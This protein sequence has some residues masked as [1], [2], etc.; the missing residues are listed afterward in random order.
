VKGVIVAAG[1]GTRFLPVTKT[2]PKEMLPILDRP[3]LDHVVRELIEADVDDLLVISSRRKRALED[4]FDRDLELEQVFEREGATA[5]RAKI[6][7]PPIRVT[8]IRQTEMR[9]AGQALLL[10][11]EF[12]GKDPVIV[13]YPDDL[14]GRPN[15]SAQLVAA[16]RETGK[17]VLA[18]HDLPGAD[19][20]RYGVL[21]VAGVGPV[22]DVR[23][24]VEK[25]LPG[26]APSSVVSLGRYL[27][28]PDLFPLLA[29]GWARHKEGEFF[30]QDAINELAA[31]GRVAARIVDAAR[32]DT[33]TPLGLLTAAI[34][35]ALERPDLEGPLRSWLLERLRD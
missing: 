12:A 34:D 9:G 15:A 1:F 19:L 13:A 5:K 24:I 6:A 20:S 21:D 29:Q 31:R 7:P 8:F 14:F 27:Y 25:P 32:W 17:S 10:A 4:W 3:S 35:E 22:R 30:P 26:H 33:G 16:Y 28:T 2:V 18:A 23:R 11:A